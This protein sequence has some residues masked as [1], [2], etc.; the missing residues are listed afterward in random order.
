MLWQLG[1]EIAL[2]L[3]LGRWD[4]FIALQGGYTFGSKSRDDIQCRSG[5]CQGTSTDAVSISGADFGLAG[6]FDY[7][8]SP[9]FSLGGDLA[10]MMLFLSR[11]P[12]PQTGEILLDDS[13]S[14]TGLALKLGA[15]AAIHF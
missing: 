15:H 11:D 10:A 3:P 2:R 5:P 7:Y 13:A 4:P 9:V 6:G 1:G 14:M 8:V 12:V